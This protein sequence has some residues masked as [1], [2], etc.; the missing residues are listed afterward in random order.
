[1]AELADAL[2]LGSSAQKVWEFESPRSHHLIEDM[3]DFV[4]LTVSVIATFV[5]FYVLFKLSKLDSLFLKL[6]QLN[7][8]LNQIETSL[9]DEL[10][11]TKND[12]NSNFNMML[13][14]NDKLLGALS[15][16]IR[17]KMEN[18]ESIV[19]KSLVDISLKHEKLITSNED[20]LEKF[21]QELQLQTQVIDKS[22]DNIRHVVEEKLEKIRIDNESKLE[23]MRQ[24]VDEKLH[25]SLEK[26]LGESFKQVSERLEMV[27]KGLGEMQALA[28]GVGDLKKV[29]TNVKNRGILGELQLE[30]ILDDILSP[31][32]YEKNVK[33]KPNSTEVVEFAIKLPGNR[34]NE[35][36]WLPIDSKF[37]IEN[38]QRLLE[39]YETGQINQI[40]ST[41]KALEQSIKPVSYTHLT[42]PTIY[43]V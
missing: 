36:M 20:K 33:T 28:N 16:E 32:F 3:I 5:A 12:I 21:T 41:Q 14:N 25:E 18:I 8:S 26:K 23:Q 38:Y 4:I 10:S 35:I 13:N 42:L 31:I 43:S 29:L 40:A 11:R 15:R 24:T 39:Y 37:P 2:D 9:K 19:S 7:N 17:E 1:M 6:D 30:K 34:D 27:H 22:L